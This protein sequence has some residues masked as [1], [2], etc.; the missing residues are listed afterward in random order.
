LVVRRRG[1]TEGSARARSLS[2]HIGQ[3]KGSLPLRARRDAPDLSMGDHRRTGLEGSPR[4]GQRQTSVVD[5]TIVVNGPPGEAFAAEHW[6]VL[7]DPSALEEAMP[8]RGAEKGEDLIKPHARCKL[9]HA[10]WIAPEDGVEEGERINQMR[11]QLEQPASFPERLEDQPKIQR[12]EVTQPTMDEPR[13]PTAGAPADV[14]TID[15]SNRQSPA[16]QVTRDATARDA[17]A[18]HSDIIHLLREGFPLTLPCIR[19]KR[20]IVQTA[21]HQSRGGVTPTCP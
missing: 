14:T 10:G 15:Q 2:D 18:H 17:G 3:L 12:L 21:S 7:E 16:S 5:L 11:R 8:L 20:A 13:R 4:D 19:R 6:L 1:V 9:G